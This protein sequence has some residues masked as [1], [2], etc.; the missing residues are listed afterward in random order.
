MSSL[1]DSEAGKLVEIVGIVTDK[2]QRTSFQ[3]DPVFY[4]DVSGIDFRISGR[5]HDSASVGDEVVLA[6]RDARW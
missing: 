3:E 6:L 2:R 1:Q 4:L 5:L